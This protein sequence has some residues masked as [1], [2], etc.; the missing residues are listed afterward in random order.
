MTDAHKNCVER[1]LAGVEVREIKKGKGT[2]KVNMDRGNCD[3]VFEN[4]DGSKICIAYLTPELKWK[5]GN[6]ALASNLIKEEEVKKKTQGQRKQK[7]F[8]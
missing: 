3:K 8:R 4:A 2:E 6:C 7:S 5:A 1:C